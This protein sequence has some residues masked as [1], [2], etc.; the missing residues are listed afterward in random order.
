MRAI[1]VAFLGTALGAYAVD[2]S[3]MT[4]PDEA[5]KCCQSM[6]C[7]SSGHS[8]ECCEIMPQVHAPFVQAPPAH[9]LSF[10]PDLIAVVSI[11]QESVGSDSA[12]HRLA[13][14]C[15]APPGSSPP[16]ATA[17]RI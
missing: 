7:S 1:L 16:T 8:Q 11:F 12:S 3:G 2:C 5:M 13:A 9:G 17:I 14:S 10:T 15:H 4:T 6:P